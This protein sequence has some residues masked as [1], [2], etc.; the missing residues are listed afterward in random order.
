MNK[1]ILLALLCVCCLALS[2]VEQ[3][4]A[5]ERIHT[6]RADQVTAP[7]GMNEVVY[8]EHGLNRT[9]TTKK[10]L[11]KSRLKAINI[12]LE[13]SFIQQ[14][15]AGYKQVMSLFR[16]HTD[17]DYVLEVRTHFFDASEF[18]SDTVSKWQ[19]IFVPANSI[20]TYKVMSIDKTTTYFRTEVRSAK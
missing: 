11:Q 1:S 20:Q 8:V 18:P 7:V 16:N 13:K 10:W 12:S 6:N 3:S 17:F 14:N 9:Y 5:E 19:R 15:E 2:V 4:Y